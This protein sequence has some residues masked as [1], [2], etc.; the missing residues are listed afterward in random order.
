MAYESTRNRNNQN[1]S[2]NQ[3]QQE[4]LGATQSYSSARAEKKEQEK[5]ASKKTFK[6]AAKGAATYFAGPAGGKAVDAISKTK[7]GQQIINK[8]GEALNKIP[9]IGK[10]SKKLNDSGALD[11]ADKAIDLTGG[12]APG[13]GAGTPPTSG[14]ATPSGGSGAPSSPST[15]V[16]ASQAGGEKTPNI[17]G[18]PPFGRK[19]KNNQQDN[20]TDEPQTANITGFGTGSMTVKIVVFGLAPLI[21]VI[22]FAVAAFGHMTNNFSDF[23]DALGASQASG[24]ETGE[25]IFEASSEEAKAFYDRIN[26]VKLRMQASGKSVDPLKIA[27][28]YHILVTND[29]DIKYDDMTEAKIEEIANAMFSGNSYN[30]DTF[31]QNLINN[32]FLSY[33]P[34]TTTSEREQLAEDVFEYIER[35]Y[36]FIGKDESSCAS[37]GSCIYEIKGFYIQGKGN[38]QKDLK[39]TDLQVRLMQ[40]GT[41]NGHNYGGTWGLPLENEELVPFEKYVLGVAY[42]EIG[43][44]APDEAIKAQMVAARSYILARPFDMGGWRKI[45]QEADGKW[46]IQV[47]SSTQDQVYCDPDKGCSSNDGQ[48]GQ[49]HSGLD[50][51]PFKRQPMPQDH[52][53]RTLANETMGEVLVNEQGNIIYTGYLSTEQNMFSSLANQGMN[54]KQ[55]LLQVYNQGRRNYGATDIHKM[56]CN[57]GSSNSCGDSGTAASGPYAG[58]KQYEGPWAGVKMGTSGK[59]IKQIGCLVT[60]ISMLIAKSGV[61]TRV[62]NFNPGTFVEFLNNNGGFSGGNFVWQSAGAAAPGFKYQGKIGLSGY[63]REQKLAQIKQLVDQGAYVVVEVKGNTGQHWVAVDSISG[64]KVMMLDPGSKSTDMWAQYNWQNTSQLAYYMVNK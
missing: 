26:T 9:G 3:D 44:T 62:N 19:P 21:L 33:L 45:E 52:K 28:V 37:L 39:I 11:A 43:P 10:A 48:W 17:A 34:K 57:N 31:K 25:I 32:I 20:S 53:M 59:T 35:Y 54:Y 18:M 41:G 38:I 23:E 40:S 29:S 14:G 46:V 56:S 7:A 8:G 49:I 1:N 4:A 36:S 64:G 58:W 6:T 51:G 22:L 12:K 55:I 50:Y 30:E 16:G 42:Q 47:A 13:G 15:G 2:Q 63:S 60:S 5:E 27:A 61:E 24:G